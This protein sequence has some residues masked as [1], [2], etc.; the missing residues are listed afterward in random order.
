MLQDQ[1][2]EESGWRSFFE[3]LLPYLDNGAIHKWRFRVLD[4]LPASCSKSLHSSLQCILFLTTPNP[5]QKCCS[6]WVPENWRAKHSNWLRTLVSI[7]IFGCK[8]GF[9]IS[10]RT[11]NSPPNLIYQRW[12]FEVRKNPSKEDC[13][14]YFFLE[15]HCW[16]T[17]LLLTRNRCKLWI[18]SCCLYWTVW[19]QEHSGLIIV[20]CYGHNCSSSKTTMNLL[21]TELWWPWATISHMLSHNVLILTTSKEE[22]KWPA[23]AW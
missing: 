7:L 17:V 16:R 13:R 15:M 5:P 6:W 21:L 9:L 12:K 1:N 18:A 11:S 20:L 10:R 2:I 22:S 14:S 19:A 8:R 4:L 23:S 3:H